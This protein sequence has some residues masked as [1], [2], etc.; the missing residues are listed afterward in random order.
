MKEIIMKKRMS[1]ITFLLTVMLL[2]PACGSKNAN[3][4]GTTE[5][6]QVVFWVPGEIPRDLQKIQDEIS[7]ITVE[8]INATVKLLAISSGNY[9]QQMN[10][11][12][13]SGEKVDVAPV[14]PEQFGGYVSN[15][16]LIPLDDLLTEYGQGILQALGSDYTKGGKVNGK[17]YGVTSIRDLALELIL[18]IRKD[19]VDK[20]H[21][22]ASKNL[23]F[24]D[25]G[26]ILKTVKGAEPNS[27]QLISVNRTQTP[28]EYSAD[29]DP[30]NDGFGVL[31]DILNKDHELK[32]VNWF[33][34]PKYAEN[35]K[36]IRSWYEAGY[37]PKDIV[38]NKE[39]RASEIKAGKGICYI[40]KGKP[41]FDAQ[42][43]RNNGTTM[44]TISISE[45]YALTSTLQAIEWTIPHNSKIPE[46]AMQ[47]MNLMYTDPDIVNLFD[48]GIEGVHYVKASDGT[49]DY[50]EGVTA[51]NSGW[52]LNQGWMFGNQFLSHIW[53]GDSTTLWK[54]VDNFNKVAV[55]SKA[56]GFTFDAS[57][58][59]TEMAALNN[60]KEQ[61]KFGLESGSMD[62]EVMLPE[63]ISKLKAAGIDEVIAEKQRQLDEWA[64]NQ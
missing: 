50:P 32:L 63:F 24:E 38:T 16:Q 22:D 36:T 62:P 1:G 59:K 3:S 21:I 11:I 48:W 43:S 4:S 44:I 49:I 33:E 20:Y 10:L 54:D 58:F 7:K 55:Q 51:M 25:V 35:L 8:K 53:K 41:G 18:C 30:L 45:P 13:A 57:K 2:F 39:G 40:Y 17:I 31:L 46:K 23:T 29:F 61:Y 5:E 19:Y 9:T 34:H 12:L 56:I 6:I 37:I 42:E 15:G 28:I 26:S 27:T 52:N 64:K 14:K 60:L 47:F